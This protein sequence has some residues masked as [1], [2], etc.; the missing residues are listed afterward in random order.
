MRLMLRK[1]Q[2]TLTRCRKLA[3]DVENAVFEQNI[4]VPSASINIILWFLTYCYEKMWNIFERIIILKFIYLINL[5]IFFY[6][7]FGIKRFM[8]FKNK[9]HSSNLIQDIAFCVSSLSNLCSNV[10]WNFNFV[11]GVWAKIGKID[12][13]D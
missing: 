8:L 5:W 7:Y 10:V 6:S 11:W 4:F 9:A 13:I 12:E 3:S 2:S 1:C